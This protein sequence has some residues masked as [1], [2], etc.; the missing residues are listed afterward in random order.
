MS[1]GNEQYV[2][3]P[4]IIAVLSLICATV[5]FG[6]RPEELQT[7][8]KSGGAYRKLKTLQPRVQQDTHTYRVGKN[9]SLA[10]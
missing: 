1:G 7:Q 5:S 6:S 9:A 10:V 2:N 4:S 3:V 8:K